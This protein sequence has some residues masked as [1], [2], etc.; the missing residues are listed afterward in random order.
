MSLGQFC[1]AAYL[2]HGCQP[3]KQAAPGGLAGESCCGVPVL[4]ARSG[5]GRRRKGRW[6]V[7]SEQPL[8]VQQVIV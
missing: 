8:L 3:D 4:T 2:L 1:G 6:W 7:C 5:A